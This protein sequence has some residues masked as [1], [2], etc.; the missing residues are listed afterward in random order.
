M[1]FI[2]VPLK[3]SSELDV[4]QGAALHTIVFFIG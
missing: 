3:V 2:S 1:I 4:C